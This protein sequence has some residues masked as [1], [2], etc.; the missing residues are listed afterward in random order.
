MFVED[1]AKEQ[2]SGHWHPLGELHRMDG[3]PRIRSKIFEDCTRTLFMWRS[4]DIRVFTVT[5][6]RIETFQLSDKDTEDRLISFLRNKRIPPLVAEK[7]QKM[8]L[9]IKPFLQAQ[10]VGHL[11]DLIRKC[12]IAW[13]TNQSETKVAFHTGIHS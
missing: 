4:L 12:L 5:A 3:W 10:F 9:S 8:F 13:R 7:H 11:E 2:E 6:M 1:A